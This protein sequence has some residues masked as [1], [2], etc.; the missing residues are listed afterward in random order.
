ML[1]TTTRTWLPIQLQRLDRESPG[2]TSTQG[3]RVQWLGMSLIILRP[4]GGR[5]TRNRTLA[6]S[7]C[8]DGTVMMTWDC[9]LAVTM[10][11]VKM[12]GARMLLLCG[13]GCSVKMAVVSG[14]LKG[15]HLTG[16]HSSLVAAVAHQ[17]QALMIVSAVVR[18][19]CIQIMIGECRY[20]EVS[21]GTVHC[22]GDMGQPPIQD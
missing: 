13:R 9:P 4:G 21:I 7:T 12:K 22:S 14:W 15:R 11:V 17:N 19:L 2:K 3:L 8:R 6:C 20:F 16:G 1:M 10:T 18:R 5:K